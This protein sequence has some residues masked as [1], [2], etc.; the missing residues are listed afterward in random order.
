MLHETLQGSVSDVFRP[1]LNHDP[2]AWFRGGAKAAPPPPAR[3]PP[4]L[5]LPP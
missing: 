5:R 1:L 3:R 4:P 2:V